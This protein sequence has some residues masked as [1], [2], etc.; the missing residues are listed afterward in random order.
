MSRGAKAFLI[1]TAAIPLLGLT[2]SPP[3]FMLLIYT[4]FVAALFARSRIETWASGI[5]LKPWLKLWIGMVLAGW[6]AECLAWAGHY[7]A[8][9]PKPILLHPQLI[10]DL[11][12][13]FGFYSGW[14]LAWMIVLRWTGFSLAAAF[15]TTGILGVFFENMGAVFVQIVADMATN[16]FI[17]VMRGAFV[18]AVYGSIVGLG[19]M[20]VLRE[21][22]A[23]R[24]RAAWA[25]YPVAFVL[26]FLLAAGGTALV[27]AVGTPMGLIPEKRPI[28]EHPLI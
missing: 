12:L 14:A 28:G 16:P 27:G 2:K 18:F 24:G 23:K 19:L 4:A 8:R 15:V 1:V 17:G 20:P 7:A 26:L 10:P 3:D 11:I 21:W 5:R 22:P 25:V 13:G 9:S 6:L